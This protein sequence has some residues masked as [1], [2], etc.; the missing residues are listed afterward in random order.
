MS[1][2]QETTTLNKI[3]SRGYWRVVIRP[4]AFQEHHLPRY[5][6][7][8]RIVERNSVQLRGWDYPHIDRSGARLHGSDWVGQESEWE[9]KIEVFR[10]YQSGLFTHFFAIAGDWRN[11]SKVW[12]PAEPGW[13]WGREIYYLN[14][15]YSFV[16]IF[17]FA[18]R[19]ALSPAGASHMI[20]EIDMEK[21]AGR[22]VT[23]RDSD[24][25]MFAEYRTEAPKWNY[26]WE[27]IQTDLIATPRELAAKASQHF[28][29]RFGL[30]LSLETMSR[31]QQ[32]MAR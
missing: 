30:V 16:E 19:L 24:I 10:I 12:R 29:A 28:F 26:R 18:A 17:K 4:T 7:L 8:F 9:D 15:I 6:D 5:D 21:L 13:A 20:V 22:R 23:T 31:L 25:A 2:V 27:G 14:T 3:R 11:Q 32:R 1:T